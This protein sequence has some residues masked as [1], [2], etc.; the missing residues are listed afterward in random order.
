MILYFMLGK[1]GETNVLG[2]AKIAVFTWTR[3]SRHIIG[4]AKGI[5]TFQPACQS[6]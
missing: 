2:H 4:T 5:S 1:S 3:G 6:P